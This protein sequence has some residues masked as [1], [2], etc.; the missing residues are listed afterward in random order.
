MQLLTLLGCQDLGSELLSNM[1]F[2]TVRGVISTVSFYWPA[3]LGH[4]IGSSIHIH[5]MKGIAHRQRSEK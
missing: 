4:H 1:R 5:L 3:Q 2:N